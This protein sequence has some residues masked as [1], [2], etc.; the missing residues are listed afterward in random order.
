MTAG[1]GALDK[2]LPAAQLM[3]SL[4]HIL[5]FPEV[6]PEDGLG[7]SVYAACYFSPA[8]PLLKPVVLTGK[9]TGKRAP[10]RSS[11]LMKY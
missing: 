8:R 7:E 11:C 3:E 1:L 9:P 5:L 2:G 10:H 6:P 4:V